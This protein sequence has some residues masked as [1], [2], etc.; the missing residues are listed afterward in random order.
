M[1]VLRAEEQRQTHR[2]PRPSSF[3]LKLAMAITGVIFVAFVFVHMIGNLKVYQGAEAFNSYAQW[4]REVGYPLIPHTGVLW[5]L[6][7]VL[8][9]SLLVHLIAA[10]MLWLRGRAARG[11][12]RRRRM[13]TGLTAFGARTM[14]LGG[15]IILVFVIIHLLDL[16]IGA[17]LAPETYRHADADGTMHAYQNLV[18]S[19][20]RVPMAVFY[21]LSMVV[22]ALHVF[23]GWR[24]VLQDVGATGRRL[25]LVWVTIGAVLAIAILIGNALIPVLVLA[26]M[27]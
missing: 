23:H 15:V 10:V 1:T 24:T 11:P 6:R 25:R 19:F 9:T 26:G 7:V 17:A 18:A 27:L 13:M 14:L 2:R 12:H 16:T 5:T 8:V 21:A 22:L 3:V 4:L 20:S